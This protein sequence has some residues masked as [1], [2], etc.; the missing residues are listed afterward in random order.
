MN[1][2]DIQDKVL[3]GFVDGVVAKVL[4]SAEEDLVQEETQERRLKNRD[5]RDRARA[6]FNDSPSCTDQYFYDT[7]EVE[8]PSPK[9]Y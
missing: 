5:L 4:N 8:Q 1:S 7:G 2:E 9:T 6:K 3:S